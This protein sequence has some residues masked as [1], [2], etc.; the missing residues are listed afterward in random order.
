MSSDTRSATRIL[1]IE[2][3]AH[4]RQGYAAYLRG[5]GYDVYEAVTGEQALTVAAD[6][7]PHVIVLDLGL[8]DID[9]WEVARRLKA[10][11]H[12]ADVPI[13]ALTGA[14]LT[15]RTGQRDARRLRPACGQAVC[16]V[17]VARH[18]S[19]VRRPCQGERRLRVNRLR[20]ASP[21]RDPCLLSPPASH[22]LHSRTSR[23]TRRR[24]S[25]RGD[26][27]RTSPRRS[28]ASARSRSCTRGP[29]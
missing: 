17:G 9:G 6:W 28:H 8:P 22:S 11:A 5:H 4:A 21:I 29:S 23:E 19:S 12:A 25:W 13:V 3:E 2:D 16:P 26:S 18:H 27:S 15:A 14:T 10:S 7:R 1:F 24:T 20:R